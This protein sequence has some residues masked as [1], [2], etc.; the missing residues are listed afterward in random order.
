MHRP[1]VSLLSTRAMD[2]PGTWNSQAGQ[3]RMISSIFEGKRGGYFVDLAAASPIV[4]SNSRA[5]ERDLDWRGLCIEGNERLT[6]KLK[7]QRKGTV[8]QSLISSR[9]ANVTYAR[10]DANPGYSRI[11]SM[12]AESSGANSVQETLT[13]DAVLRAHDAP[14]VT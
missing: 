6:K 12:Q 9:A 8:V 13:L 4:L 11:V 5:L 3:D 7:A 14:A 1:C 2:S 10:S